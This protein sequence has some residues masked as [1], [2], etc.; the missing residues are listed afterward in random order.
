MTATLRRLF[1]RRPPGG[2]ACAQLVELVTDYLEDALS[3]EDR[4]RFEEHVSRCDGCTTYVEQIRETLDLL[5]RVTPD[6]LSPEARRDLLDAFR[7]WQAGG[8]AATDP[9]PGR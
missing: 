7:D 4:R 1:R 3:P 5:G 6:D 9:S 2:L 8:S